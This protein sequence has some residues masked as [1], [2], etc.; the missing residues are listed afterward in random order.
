VVVVAAAVVLEAGRV[1]VVVVWAATEV[2]VVAVGAP[3]EVLVATSSP[4][5]QATSTKDRLVATIPALFRLI[6]LPVAA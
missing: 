3:A 1:L 5:P 2:V 4:V 6:G